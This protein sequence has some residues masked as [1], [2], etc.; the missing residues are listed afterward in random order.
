MV[1]PSRVSMRRTKTRLLRRPMFFT[2]GKSFCYRKKLNWRIQIS[3][4]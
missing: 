1:L 3:S 2:A 4:W